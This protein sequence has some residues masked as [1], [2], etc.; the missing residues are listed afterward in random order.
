MSDNNE[1]T[2]GADGKLLIVVV[3]IGIF[4]DDIIFLPP[5]SQHAPE[6]ADLER[7]RGT[8][9]FRVFNKMI[10]EPSL[11]VQ[12]KTFILTS[13]IRHNV[14]NHFTVSVNADMKQFWWTF[15]DDY[16]YACNTKAALQNCRIDAPNCV[17]FFYEKMEVN[18]EVDLSA[19][20]R[21]LKQQLPEI[22]FN[23]IQIRSGIAGVKE[24]SRELQPYASIAC[25]KILIDRDDDDDSTH[26]DLG[27]YNMDSYLSQQDPSDAEAELLVEGEMVDPI[28]PKSN[29][30][31]TVPVKAKTKRVAEKV[32]QKAPIVIVSSEE[33]NEGLV[34][35]DEEMDK[36]LGKRFYIREGT[37][38]AIGKITQCFR[39]KRRQLVYKVV[40]AKENEHDY[41][42]LLE[43]RQ[44]LLNGS[45]G[46]I[47]DHNEDEFILTAIRACRTEAPRKFPQPPDYEFEIK[48]DNLPFE[49]FQYNSSMFT[50]DTMK[51]FLRDEANGLRYTS[52]KNYYDKD[53]KVEWSQYRFCPATASRNEHFKIT[54]GDGTVVSK[55]MEQ[56]VTKFGVKTIDR[57]RL[58]HDLHSEKLHANRSWFQMDSGT[59]VSGTRGL[60]SLG[61]R[62]S[63]IESGTSKLIDN[64]KWMV[65][66]EE[67]WIKLH[68]LKTS[69]IYCLLAACLNALLLSHEE[70]LRLFQNLRSLH[71]TS[72]EVNAGVLLFQLQKEDTGPYHLEFE[73]CKVLK[74]FRELSTMVEEPIGESVK[75]VCYRTTNGTTHAIC[76]D[77]L[78]KRILDSEYKNDDILA[79]Q[80]F[81]PT[82]TL[83][84]N[85]IVSLHTEFDVPCILYVACWKLKI[86]R[87]RKR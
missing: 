59:I 85:M 69:G 51:A 16:V 6:L 32:G 68:V 45:N 49:F 47:M 31:K 53:Q 41:I 75:I 40:Y 56:A 86:V 74:T 78:G 79:Y 39:N 61:D 65:L 13:V 84:K 10:A 7:I 87:K 77:M 17:A 46:T 24:M 2:L 82:S 33:Q 72:G 23:D 9:G 18:A 3:E 28:V 11:I 22:I 48:W 73:R 50:T 43:L 64:F 21:R 27:L 12:D 81:H 71:H 19:L 25:Y 63:V 5:S 38:T 26:S 42:G 83:A 29:V 67:E 76:W 36:I 4:E 55:T 66:D 57:I 44:L 15:D 37:K 8:T 58:Q 52:F 70:C 80:K 60:D 20:S 34:P 54:L 35:C 62:I 14:A 1:F 30:S